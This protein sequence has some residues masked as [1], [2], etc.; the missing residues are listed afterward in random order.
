M[1]IRKL[2]PLILMAIMIAAAANASDSLTYSG[3]AL[4]RPQTPAPFL[5]DDDSVSVQAQ[6]G[7]DWQ[8]WPGFRAHVHLLA[9]NEGDRARRGRVGIV[10]S[11]AEK[12]FSIPDGRL[13]VMAG[14]FFLPTSRE[15]VDNL[16]ETP[17]TISS[18]ALNTWLGEEFR[19][20]GVDLTYLRRSKRAGT[21]TGG[22]TLFAGND[23]FG[24]LPID[25]GWAIHDQWT[26]LG[27]HVPSRQN[28]YTSVSAETDGR[29]G[30][31]GRVKWNTDRAVIQ[32]TRI[33][34]RADA[35]RYG[36]LF[37]WATRYNII[38]AEYSWREWTAAG[39]S[40]WGS[41]A[42]QGRRRR[43]YDIDS[44]YVLLSRR[45]AKFRASIRADEFK[46]RAARNH[47]FTAALFWDVHPRLRTGIEGISSKG[48]KRLA[49][50]FRYRL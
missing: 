29:L 41:T 36:E 40:G 32:Y 9:R 7:I 13:R 44:S 26:V 22:A 46:A 5:F 28:I 6:L 11:F 38:G 20:V 30:W 25:R 18:S 31:S 23:T 33:D 35:L 15:N 21:F 50:E 39:E 47:A 37:N 34:N 10:Q 45:I 1:R 48:Q 43:T 19:P 2:G 14:A 24:A 3:F 4:L 8:P 49:L 16:W 17:Y 27:E 12:N 42:I